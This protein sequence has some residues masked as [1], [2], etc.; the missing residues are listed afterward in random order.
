MKHTEKE[1]KILRAVWQKIHQQKQSPTTAAKRKPLWR[2]LAAAAGV[3]AAVF[4]CFILLSPNTDHKALAYHQPASL[5]DLF[6]SSENDSAFPE[7]AQDNVSPQDGSQDGSAGLLTDTQAPFGTAFALDMLKA[8]YDGENTLV[9]PLS[10]QLPLLLTY[11]G[12]DG[13][14]AAQLAAALGLNDHQ[15]AHLGMLAN[16]LL[17]SIFS[18]GASSYNSLWL[19][20]GY[21][22]Q[23]DFRQTAL[24]HYN[25]GIGVAD[26]SD[27][28]TIE[29]INKEVAAQ[30]DNA[31]PKLLDSLSSD[32]V[33]LLVNTLNFKDDWLHPFDPDA[34]LKS[35]PFHTPEGESSV[36]M[37]KKSLSCYYYETDGYQLISLPYANSTIE[38][39][40]L[41][42]AQEQ[43]IEETL[44]SL[45][46]QTWQQALSSGKAERVDI[47]LPP[48]EM[49]STVDCKP[50]LHSM[51]VTD[52]FEPSRANLSKIAAEDDTPLALFV[53]GIL[54]KS[55][56]RVDESGAEAHSA[57]GITMEATS[58]PL[59][60]P[61]KSFTANRP[62]LFYL[63]NSAD[64][65]ILF[66]GAVT[67]PSAT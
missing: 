41:L 59:E 12:A 53:N 19:S 64:G 30:T 61:N 48:F 17:S 5:E 37:M 65:S 13:E 49:N 22:L 20:E 52:L 2:P 10:L 28:Q 26:F 6:A 16:S 38:M 39:A 8:A 46:E 67:D 18:S 32:T 43:T 44:P 21:T 42:P 50:L 34:T 36:S 58:A 63:Y 40:F 29:A 45:T 55:T 35:Q 60:G 57:T 15:Q 1:Q 56:I 33:L 25:T 4:L 66:T 7:Y 11:S 9:S 14:T 24:Q 47:L 31:I 27:P 23:D 62:F 51:G 3:L 54:Q